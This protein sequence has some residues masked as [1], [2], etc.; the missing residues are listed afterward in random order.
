[1]FSPKYVPETMHLDAL[2][3]EMQDT[4]N[5]L[6]I[7]VNEYG[8]T[9]GVVSMEDIIEELV[10]E[11]YDEHDAAELQ[12]I[13]QQQDGTYRVLCGTNVDKMFDYFDVEEEVDAT[14]V[15]GWVVLQIDKLPEVGDKFTYVADYKQFDVVVTKADNRKSLEINMVVTELEREE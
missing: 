5:H 2:L 3:K 14:T 13:V 12:D 7:V 1:M 9:S 15:N 11:I 6:A 8:V 10:G 4:H